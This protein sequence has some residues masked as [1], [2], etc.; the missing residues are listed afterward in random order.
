MCVLSIKVP[1][2]KSL[3]T[4]LMI[5]VYNCRR[6]PAKTIT[7]ADYANDIVLLANAPAQAETL[8]HS[9]EWATAGISLHVNAHKMKYMCFYQTGELST[10]NNSALKLV[11][12]FTRLPK[13]HCLINQDRHWHVTSMDSYQ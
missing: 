13:E 11:D 9:L 6:Y 7:D 8:L 3:E 12:K 1:I 2:Q 5:L 4:Y 10:L